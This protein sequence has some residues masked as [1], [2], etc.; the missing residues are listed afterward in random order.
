MCARRFRAVMKR[1]SDEPARRYASEALSESMLAA[2]DELIRGDEND[3]AHRHA[4]RHDDPRLRS[5]VTSPHCAQLRSA[6]RLGSIRG[7]QQVDRM[8][9]TCLHAR[10]PQPRADLH[11]APGI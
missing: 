8:D 3:A 4:V 7:V 5:A 9:T 2:D 11:E 1:T 6:W 10:T